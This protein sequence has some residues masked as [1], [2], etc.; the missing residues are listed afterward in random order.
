MVLLQTIK[1]LA[2]CL[3][4][5]KLWKPGHVSE[6]ERKKRAYHNAN[7]Q[8]ADDEL[9]LAAPEKGVDMHQRRLARTTARA[10]P[11]AK[12]SSHWYEMARAKSQPKRDAP[13]QLREAAAGVIWLI[14]DVGM[15]SM[16]YFRR[17]TMRALS[18]S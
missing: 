16:R 18:R 6:H 9:Y 15:D 17:Q 7:R 10:V 2:R 8:H 1:P 12:P 3:P 14:M 11:A 13:K 4:Q 5:P